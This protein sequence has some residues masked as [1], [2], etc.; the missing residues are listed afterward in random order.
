MFCF[1][2]LEA[3]HKPSEQFLDIL[4]PLRPPPLAL[5]TIL[6]NKVHVVILTF[7]KPPPPSTFTWFMNNPLYKCNTFKMRKARS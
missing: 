6:L 4:T 2:V 3:I 5:W 7:G 1:V